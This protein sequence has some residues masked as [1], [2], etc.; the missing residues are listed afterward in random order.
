M[1]DIDEAGSFALGSTRVNRLGYGA[2]QLVGPGVVGPPKD[3]AAALAVLRLAIA[4]GVKRI[5]ISD[6]HGPQVANQIIREALRPYPVGLGI[7]TKIS[8]RRGSDGAWLPAFTPPELTQAGHDNRRNL[9][10]DVLAVINSRSMV[11]IHAPAEG[12]IEEPLT[13]LA[14]L[15]RHGPV[16][17]IGLSNVTPTELAEGRW[18]RTSFASR[19]TKT[20]LTAPTMG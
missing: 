16:R 14:E 5:D 11:G 18:V 4:S 20:L 2:M 19:T 15:H 9:R 3:R 10:L 17:Q 7:V 8:A 12:S 1:P 13:V 6:F